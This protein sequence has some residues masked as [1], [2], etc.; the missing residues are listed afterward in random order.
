MP[1][2][3][4]RPCAYIGCRMFAANGEQ[5]CAEHKKMLDRHYNRFQ[6]NPETK[7]HYGSA[8]KRIRNKFIKANPLCEECKDNGVL[9]P[10]QEVHHILALSKGGGNEASNLMSL[11]KSCHSR[12]TAQSGGRWSK[13]EP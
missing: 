3:P 6:R 13:N 1:Y 2:K 9:T 4:R 7:K 12:K 11:C 5:Y 8:W 10:A